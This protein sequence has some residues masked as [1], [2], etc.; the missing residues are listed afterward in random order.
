[1]SCRSCSRPPSSLG[2][3]PVAPPTRRGA[4]AAV[5]G[6]ALALLAWPRALVAGGKG[7]V[8]VPLGK[9]P[10]LKTV[11]G[12]MQTRIRGKEILLVRDGQNSAHAFEAKCP[13]E[14][15]D[16]N[17]VPAG[18]KLECPC[19]DAFF[20]LSG[21]VLQGPPPRALESYPAIVDGERILIRIPE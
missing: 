17:Y 1:M 18:Q 20:D 9:A 7:W 5:A 12:S 19:H 14:F 6:A 8:A 21:K 3:E 2:P 15:C 10:K 13:H 16:I 11:G 4:L